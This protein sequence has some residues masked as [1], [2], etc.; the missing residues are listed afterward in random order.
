MNFEEQLNELIDVWAESDSEVPL[1]E[2][3]KY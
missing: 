1:Y 3:F 2:F